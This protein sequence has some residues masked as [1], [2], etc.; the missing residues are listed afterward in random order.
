MRFSVLSIT[1]S[2]RRPHRGIIERITDCRRLRRSILQLFFRMLSSPYSFTIHRP[3]RRSVNGPTF[4]RWTS[5]LYTSN[6]FKIRYWGYIVL[7]PTVCQDGLSKK[8]QT[9]IP[10]VPLHLV[11]IPRSFLSSINL[12]TKV[13]TYGLSISRRSVDGSVGHHFCK[14]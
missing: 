13:A 14:F 6:L 11:R 12:Q 1:R 2:S 5:L 4:R 7:T 3:K 10:F 9:V 8:R